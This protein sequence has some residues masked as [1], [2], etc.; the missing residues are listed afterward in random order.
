MKSHLCIITALREEVAPLVERLRHSE[1]GKVEDYTIWTGEISG[2]RVA[3]VKG[4][5]GAEKA[6]RAVELS[7]ELFDPRYV[8][9][10]GTTGSVSNSLRIGDFILP[11][12]LI[13]LSLKESDFTPTIQPASHITD[14]VDVDESVLNFFQGSGVVVTRGIAEIDFPLQSNALRTW[15]H[16]TLEV[17]SVDWESY[18]VVKR[19][20]ELGKETCAFLSV[21]DYGDTAALEHFK[22][23]LARVSKI[24]AKQIQKVCTRISVSHL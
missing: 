15:L 7:V 17:D 4:A 10:F 11:R 19:A 22:K 5:L 3:V 23:N 8:F 13:K 21:S 12:R 1:H 20:Q 9:R 6:G 2:A 14:I 18:S 16:D 24:G